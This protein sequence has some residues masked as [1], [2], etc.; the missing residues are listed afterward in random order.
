MKAGPHGRRLLLSALLTASVRWV[1]AV[2]AYLSL[3]LAVPATQDPGVVQAVWVG[4]DVIG[5]RVI[6]PLAVATV[7]SGVALA[8]TSRWG[9][10]RRWWVVVSLVGITVL[11]AVLVLHIPDVST[12]ADLAR[13]ANDEV[14]LRMGSD[15]GHAML[16]R[17]CLM[18]LIVL[19][20]VS[21][22]AG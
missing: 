22:L 11:A 21:S 1:R 17:V 16:R 13:V 3:A 14:L 10:L 4:M 19:N 2:L 12:Q 5:W 7:V 9:L 20:V 18:S 15:V 8:R 6:V